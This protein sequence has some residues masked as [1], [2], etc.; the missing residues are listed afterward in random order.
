MPSLIDTETTYQFVP[1]HEGRL[2]PLILGRVIPWFLRRQ[3]ISEIEVRGEEKLQLLIE[4]ERGILLAPNH[5]RMSDALVLQSLAR[6]LRHPFFVMASAHLF[7]GGRLKTF[8]LRRMGAFS[9]YREGVDRKAVQKGIDILTE[10]K[11]PL[12]LFPEGALS[13]ANDRLN[14]LMEGVSFIAR[15]S[16]KKRQGNKPAG[17]R[18][19]DSSGVFIVPIALRYLFKGDIEAAAAPRLAE[20]ERRLSWKTQEQLPLVERIQK[21][22]TALLALKELEYLDKPQ[23]GTLDER[24]KRLID[25][26]LVPLENEWLGEIDEISVIGRVKEL[27]RK[28]LPDMIKAILDETEMDRRWGQLKRMEL[29][30]QLS[31]YPP[32]YVTSNPTADRILETLGRFQEHLTG[33]QQIQSPTKVVIQ[34]G[35][36]IPVDPK[37]DRSAPSDQL[38]DSLEESLTTMLASLSKECAMSEP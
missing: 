14:S 20:I 23:P 38:L 13:Y 36:P 4:E 28:L 33:A 11:R 19:E 2:S 9:V 31:L 22:G 21:I 15:M 18:S 17:E 32:Q 29:A 5:C 1:P 24:L 27:R 30:Q 3:G 35:D 8:L 26:L 16:A 12:V 25:H 7:R 37:R 6:K 34:V 10:G